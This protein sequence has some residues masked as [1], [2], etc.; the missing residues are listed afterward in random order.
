MILVVTVSVRGPHP[1]YNSRRWRSC[2]QVYYF[3]SRATISSSFLFFF[4]GSSFDSNLPP[5]YLSQSNWVSSGARLISTEA[6]LIWVEYPHFMDR[7]EIHGIRFR[8]CRILTQ[9]LGPSSRPNLQSLVN[10]ASGPPRVAS[11]GDERVIS[12]ARIGSVYG[13]TIS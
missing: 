10:A 5:Q 13:D 12:M 8:Y 3:L 9:K 6:Q 11:L 1:K 7:T 2:R 4:Q